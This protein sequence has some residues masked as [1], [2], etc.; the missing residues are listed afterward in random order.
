[1]LC[2][3]VQLVRIR[4]ACLRTHGDEQ[5]GVAPCGQSNVADTREGRK[6]VLLGVC[7]KSDRVGTD[8]IKLV[9]KKYLMGKAIRV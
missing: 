8:T 3:H 7:Y 2:Q 5:A 4:P 1:M 9:L 6:P